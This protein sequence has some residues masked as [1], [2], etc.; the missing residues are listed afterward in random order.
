MNDIIIKYLENICKN[1][2]YNTS[3]ILSYLDY[4]F[5][6]IIIDDCSK[7][8]IRTINLM[9]NENYVKITSTIIIDKNDYKKKEYIEIYYKNKIYNI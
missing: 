9:V 6:S 7:N 5:N 1:K 2:I 3:N 4:H 8:D